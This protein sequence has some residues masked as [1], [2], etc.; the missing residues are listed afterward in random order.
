MGVMIENTVLPLKSVYEIILIAKMRVT[1]VN[2]MKHNRK[3]MK[4][5]LELMKSPRLGYDITKLPFLIFLGE[6]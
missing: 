4:E 5:K 3:G 1:L 2:S 6:F